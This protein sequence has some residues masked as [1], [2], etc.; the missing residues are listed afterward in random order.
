MN[1][2]I[3][4]EIIEYYITEQDRL[5]ST[6]PTIESKQLAIDNTVY[7][8]NNELNKEYI[9][10]QKELKNWQMDMVS[11]IY[12][13]KEKGMDGLEADDYPFLYENGFYEVVYN[14]FST[15]SKK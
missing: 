6:C 7:I 11:L 2:K 13:Y 4:K 10:K 5:L 8:F 9:D 15:L 12:T 14:L 1:K 3:I